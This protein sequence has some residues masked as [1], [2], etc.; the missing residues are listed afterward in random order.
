MTDTYKVFL[1]SEK[2]T[3]SKPASAASESSRTNG[4]LTPPKGNHL[5]G[6]ATFLGAGGGTSASGI[7]TSAL[8]S[9]E[10]LTR[11]V[12]DAG[13]N[14]AAVARTERTTMSCITLI[15]CDDDS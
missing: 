5:A 10:T 12:L 11:T 3:G 9:A 7:A 14:A 1:V 2:P 6:S 8:F 4:A 15:N 13:A